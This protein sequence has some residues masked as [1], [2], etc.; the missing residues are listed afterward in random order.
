MV[1]KDFET[2]VVANPPP[3]FGGRYFIFVK[4]VTDT[5]IVGYGEV[6]CA[7]FSA[8]T[9]ETMLKDTAERY[10]VGHDP[11]HVETLWR[12]VYGSAITCDLMFLWWACCRPLRW[13]AGTS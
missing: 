3:R 1:I 8:A 2:F 13:H 11:F 7:T 4:L 6:Y 12:R 10:A 5:G 9:V